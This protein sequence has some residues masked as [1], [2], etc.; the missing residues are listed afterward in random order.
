MPHHFVSVQDGKEVYG[1]LRDEIIEKADISF[2]D[3][4]GE[5][6]WIYKA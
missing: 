1:N 3:T 5:G 6:G 2:I 4:M